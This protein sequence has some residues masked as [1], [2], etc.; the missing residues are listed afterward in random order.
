MFKKTHRTLV[1]ANE[2]ARTSFEA[3]TKRSSGKDTY[4]DPHYL[5]VD[6]ED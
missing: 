3:L 4:I 1:S 6:P 2:R 5:T